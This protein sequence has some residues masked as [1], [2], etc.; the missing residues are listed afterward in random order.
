MKLQNEI[1]EQEL[2]GI[3]FKLKQKQNFSFLKETE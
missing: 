2:N 3:K 1:I